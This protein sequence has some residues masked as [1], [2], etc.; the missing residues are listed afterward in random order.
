MKVPR[1]LSALGE[2]EEFSLE[3][4]E[5][6]WHIDKID[7]AGYHVSPFKTDEEGRLV[8]VEGMAARTF[9]H[10]NGIV[11]Y[12]AFG[13]SARK[14]ADYLELTLPPDNDEG[15][16]SNALA[17]LLCTPRIRE[18]IEKT[19][20]QALAQARQALGLPGVEQVVV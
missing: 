11:V 9:A 3:G 13:S 4:S 14:D 5:I 17:V 16:V 10:P 6:V 2:G 15:R 8:R 19:D 20:P 12:D 7:E 1:K 18:F